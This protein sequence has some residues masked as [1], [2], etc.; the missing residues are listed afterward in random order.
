[1]VNK[2]TKIII[3]IVLI[4]LSLIFL[5]SASSVYD[6]RNFLGNS[7]FN[8]TDIN[9][10]SINVNRSCYTEDCEVAIYYNGSGLVIKVN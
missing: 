4:V 9:A 1:M 8:V 5:I 3:A 2:K 10:S 7:I 6:N